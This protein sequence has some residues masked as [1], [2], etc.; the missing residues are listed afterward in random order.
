[1]QVSAKIEYAVRALVQLAAEGG[2]P[3]KGEKLAEAQQI[4][5]KFL[6]SILAQ[7]RHDG[8]LTS[9]R[10]GDGGYWL[11]RPATEIT[12]ADVMRATEGPLAR[13]RGLP[14][15]TVYYQGAAA[16]LSEVWIAVRASLRD[17]LEQ[18][19]LADLVAGRLPET[20]TDLIADPE[21]RVPH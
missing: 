1:M 18:V 13:V 12:V 15:E 4:P 16:R 3:V 21:A 19:T 14:P 5:P 6:E 11:A 20:V 7:L 17:V 8:L 10:G 2:G 9:R